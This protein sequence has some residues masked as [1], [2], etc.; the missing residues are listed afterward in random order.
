M[1]QRLQQ[2]A[3]EWPANL[4]K[5]ETTLFFGLG[6]VEAIIAVF[7]LTLPLVVIDNTLQAL[8]V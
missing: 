7:A 1:N 2:L 4:H 6:A 3:Y 5:Y 8:P